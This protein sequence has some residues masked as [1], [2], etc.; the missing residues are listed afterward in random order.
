MSEI[1]GQVEERL[2]PRR[3]RRPPPHSSTSDFSLSCVTA[4]PGCVEIRNNR[5][6][7]DGG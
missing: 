6:D 3:E 4:V 7:G 5:G 1:Q 2:T